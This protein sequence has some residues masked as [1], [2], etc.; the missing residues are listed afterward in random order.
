MTSVVGSKRPASRP[1]RSTGGNDPSSTMAA[2][3]DDHDSMGVSASGQRNNFKS[4]QGSVSMSREGF[5]KYPSDNIPA[6][7]FGIST[8][9]DCR[10]VGAPVHTLKHIEHEITILN[11]D[12]ANNN[13]IPCDPSV[14]FSRIEFMSNGAVA[15]VVMYENEFYIDKMC[16]IDD[17]EIAQYSLGRIYNPTT[18]RD[19]GGAAPAPTSRYR[20]HNYDTPWSYSENVGVGGP[21]PDWTIAQNQTK[22]VYVDYHSFLTDA[23][24]FMPA[25]TVE[26]RIRFYTGNSVY[27]TTSPS[28]VNPTLISVNTYMRGTIYDPSVM[29]RLKKMYMSRTSTTRCITYER[30]TIATSITSGAESQDKQLTALQGRYAYMFFMLTQTPYAQNQIYSDFSAKDTSVNANGTYWKAVQDVT[31]LD[32]NQTPWNFVK[33]PAAY[34]KNSVWGDHF[35][36][37]LTF[38][39]EIILFPFST[40]C[41]IT[42]DH[43]TDLGSMQFDGNWTLRFTPIS[44]APD[45]IITAGMAATIILVAA[46]Y[47]EFSQI[48]GGKVLFTKLN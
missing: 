30:Q 21:S 11:S 17:L 16:R 44:V 33:I 9:F 19:V 1:S 46:R 37:A 8:Q 40:C 5:N 6:N 35:K 48:P 29:Q 45:N 36:S 18:V 41:Q 3:H 24:L 43:G 26:P 25:L 28:Q 39:K 34:L 47:S 42:Q 13:L 31:L 23:H 32:S 27:Q 4:G 2:V 12:P 38:E 15:D 10:L 14:W 7:A 22:V 20:L